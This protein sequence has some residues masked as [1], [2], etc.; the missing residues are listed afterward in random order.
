MSPSTAKQ[1]FDRWY[2][3]PLK[4]IESLE[5]GDGAFVALA[6]SCFLYE[7]YCVAYL[8]SK[9]TKATD[10]AKLTQLAADFSISEDT[11]EAFWKVIR[12]G[13]LHQGMGLQKSTASVPLPTW[14]VSHEFQRIELETAPIAHLKIQP[15]LFRDRV[16]ELWDAHPELIDSNA[17]FPWA[18]IHT[19]DE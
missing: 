9:N 1:H 3:A 15:W 14:S 17:S 4:M 8:R 13:F 12:N 10:T 16:F 6:V 19:A 7:R 5:N 2:K 11:A 18:T